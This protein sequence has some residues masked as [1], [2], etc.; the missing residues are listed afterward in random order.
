MTC[1]MPETLRIEPRASKSK[2]GN[3][4]VQVS[5]S[6]LS[7]DGESDIN[8]FLGFF[9]QVAQLVLKMVTKRGSTLTGSWGDSS[10]DKSTCC[11][12]TKT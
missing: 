7:F 3:S 9:Q 2:K 5:A 11:V 12:S 1:K 4:G 8:A 10:V 6:A